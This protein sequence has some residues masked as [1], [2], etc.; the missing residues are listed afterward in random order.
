MGL[1][2]T[3][4]NGWLYEIF[5]LSTRVGKRPVSMGTSLGVRM[6]EKLLGPLSSDS[7]LRNIYS[8]LAWK[9]VRTIHEK[10][11]GNIPNAVIIK[12]QS[13]YYI[14]IIARIHIHCI[15][16]TVRITIHQT[17]I[18]CS[19]IMVMEGTELLVSSATQASK[20]HTELCCLFIIQPYD[21]CG[22]EES[23]KKGF[24]SLNHCTSH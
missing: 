24:W 18:T 8:M 1:H 14:C 4:T 5:V 11:H 13:L 12:A 20:Q 21:T 19:F 22:V 7:N 2:E 15:F 3:A 17:T 9:D 6:D 10:S 16:I 23:A